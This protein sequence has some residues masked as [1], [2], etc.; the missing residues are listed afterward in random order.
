MTMI[1][2]KIVNDVTESIIHFHQQ[3]IHVQRLTSVH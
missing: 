3:L 2:S 1:S